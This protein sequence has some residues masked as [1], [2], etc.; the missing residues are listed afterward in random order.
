MIISITNYRIN[1][2]KCDLAVLSSPFTTTVVVLSP[3]TDTSTSHPRAGLLFPFAG[4]GE[5]AWPLGQQL[6]ATVGHEVVHQHHPAVARLRREQYIFVSHTSSIL[7]G[8]I[9]IFIF[10]KKI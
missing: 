5:P 8:T 7:S 10:F 6:E 2:Y 4:D 3:A 1:K 9:F